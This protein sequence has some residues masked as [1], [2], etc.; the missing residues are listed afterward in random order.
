MKKSILFYIDQKHRDL[1]SLSLIGYFLKS[2]GYKVGYQK[3]WSW[4]TA[5]YFDVI[6]VP[7]PIFKD[8]EKWTKN[9][10]VI[11]IESEGA[12]Q[13][14][15]FKRKINYYPH[16]YFFW[17]KTECDKYKRE[18]S[19]KNVK[20]SVKGSPRLDFFQPPFIKNKNT[21]HPNKQKTITIATS[22]QEAHIDKENINK[23][24]DRRKT[25]FDAS[26]DYLKMIEI[27]KLLLKKTTE[28]VK[29]ILLNYP[30]LKVILKPHPNESVIF[31]KRFL[32]DLDNENFQLL[33]GKNI[34][35]LLKLSD[36]HIAHNAC[37]TIFEAN[38]LN[39]STVEM[40]TEDS[41]KIVHEDHR[42]IANYKINDNNDFDR[43]FKAIKNNSNNN[44]SDKF[45]KYLK[46]YYYKFDGK[47]CFSYARE[48]D[49]FIINNSKLMNRSVFNSLTKYFYFYLFSIKD[50]FFKNKTN[51]IDHKG[52]YDNRISKKS[53]LEWYKIFDQLNIIN[54]IRRKL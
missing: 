24:L 7:K 22:T 26:A 36:L 13:D 3:L 6:I 30:N 47:R 42:D 53:Y 20:Y 39:I 46:K 2:F 16:L 21:D 31:W 54:N 27:S 32:A 33:M 40:I 8:I 5:N 43:A 50:L 9:K 35:E 18:L 44:F 49:S 51:K 12:N 17:S 48:I 25:Q 1:Q 45:Q 11:I 34:D 29:H 19:N 28:L 10:I 14:V 38:L 23:V 52:R 41:H 4:E 37:T 15:N